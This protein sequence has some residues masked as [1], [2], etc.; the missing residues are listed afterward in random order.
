MRQAGI[1]AAAGLYALEHHVEGLARDHERARALAETLAACPHVEI[2]LDS[3]QSN[4]VLFTPLKNTPQEVCQ[5]LDDQV[6]LVPFGVGQVRAVLHRD[7][8][9]LD[10]ERAQEALS[11]YLS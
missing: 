9:D 2:N 10:L 8:S 4:I 5:A 6:R 3:V 7:I 11:T 1:L